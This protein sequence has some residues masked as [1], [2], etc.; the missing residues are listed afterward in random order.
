MPKMLEGKVA[1]VTGAG[2][3]IGREIAILMAQHGAKVI[4]NDVGASV[5][6]EGQDAT[7]AEQTKAIIV[8]NGGTAEIST[9]SVATWASAQKIVQAALDHFGRIDIVVNNAGILRD[10]I[11][12]RMTPEDWDAVIAVHL[13]GS[14]YVS[15][16]AATH[17]RQQQSGAFVHMTS[18]SG[19]IGNFGQANYTAA[20]LG[21]VALSKSIALDM[22]RFNVRSNCIAPFAWSR[23]TGTIPADTPEQKRRVERIMKMTP[24]KNAPLAVF[25]SSDAAKDVTGQIFAARMN[26]IFLFNQIRP[27]RS[28]HRAEGWTPESIAEYALPALQPSFSKLERSGDVF[29]WDPI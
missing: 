21:I 28:V 26:E 6:G 27:I 29:C 20:K 10:Q 24:D 5:S 15:R 3:G 14:F 23:M 17:F 2:N 8:Q 18:T 7:P 19:L 1:I 25:L 4:V 12:H 13:S 22:A 11:F 9:D 16:A